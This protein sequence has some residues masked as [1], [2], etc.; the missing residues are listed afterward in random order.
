MS[1]APPGIDVFL[2][3]LNP[4]FVCFSAGLLSHR[5]GAAQSFPDEENCKLDLS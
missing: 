4:P 2:L 3:A 1:F 5:Q